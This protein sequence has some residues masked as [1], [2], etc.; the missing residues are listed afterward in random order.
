MIAFTGPQIV[1]LFDWCIA[2]THFKYI[3]KFVQ[4]EKNI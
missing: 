4:H 1:V 2:K 3:I